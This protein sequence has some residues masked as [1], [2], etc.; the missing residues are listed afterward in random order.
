M[1][2]LDEARLE[3]DT[4]FSVFAEESAKATRHSLKAQAARA[5][6]L[7]PYVI[8][9][10]AHCSFLACG[11]A[12]RSAAAINSSAGHTPPARTRA[13]RLMHCFFSDEDCLAASGGGRCS[14]MAFLRRKR[15]RAQS[16]S[17]IKMIS[18][19]HHN[20]KRKGQPS[21]IVLT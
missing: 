6:Y 8:A 1:H 12:R 17:D 3:R 14:R 9:F 4:G 20:Q 13:R 2:E 15:N 19:T 18:H 5:R 11:R 16:R 10:A 21:F 7:S